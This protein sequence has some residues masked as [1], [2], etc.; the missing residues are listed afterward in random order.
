MEKLTP[1]LERLA[2]K[3]GVTTDM[4]WKALLRQAL[5]DGLVS[6][7]QYVVVIVWTA[8]LVRLSYRYRLPDETN[9]PLDHPFIMV[10][11]SIVWLATV[12]LVLIALFTLPT[13]LAAFFNPEYWALKKVLS[14]LGTG[15]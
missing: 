1:L 11:G 2:E 10:G 12:A 6:L 4:L 9:D 15:Y 7:V 3:L 14:L 5:L 8:Y 13:T